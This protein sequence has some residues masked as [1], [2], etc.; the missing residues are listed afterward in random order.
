MIQTTTGL[1]ATLATLNF[2]INLAAYL[3]SRSPTRAGFISKISRVLGRTP[4]KTVLTVMGKVPSISFLTPLGSLLSDWRKTLRLTS[5]IPLYIKLKS[6]MSRKNF[7]EMD[8]VLRRVVLLQC[9]AYITFQAIENI[10]HLHA[11]GIL[12]PSIV[13]KRG[14]LTIWIA[15]SCRAWC[16]GILCDFLRLWRVAVIEKSSRSKT[17]QEQED[18]D[19]TWWN[20]L[21]V[22]ALWL[23]VAVHASYYPEGVR[24][25]NAGT[26]AFLS[27]LAGWN[28]FENHW[29]ATA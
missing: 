16:V 17:A 26:V 20:H 29:R 13:E 22:A 18:L 12:A 2:S 8:P 27:L 7:G 14:G 6:L 28:N 19:R 25:M 11:K 24:S 3:Y 10:S 4:S 9:I 21:K 1:G 5:L 23:P 15:W